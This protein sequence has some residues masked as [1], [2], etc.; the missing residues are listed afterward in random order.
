[1][2]SLGSAAGPPTAGAIINAALRAIF[3]PLAIT[4]ALP[5]IGR[6]VLRHEVHAYIQVL[7][8]TS[9]HARHG[10]EFI[11]AHHFPVGE[12]GIVSHFKPIGEPIAAA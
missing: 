11:G 10:D 9:V 3:S 2:D 12:L 4:F 8:W 1:M 7:E 5:T 6:T